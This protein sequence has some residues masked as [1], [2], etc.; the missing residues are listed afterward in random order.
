M[1]VKE[2][3]RVGI[4][5]GYPRADRDD[6]DRAKMTSADQLYVNVLRRSFP[7]FQLTSLFPADLDSPIPTGAGL[8]DFDAFIWTGSKLTIYKNEPN[9]TR[10]IEFSKALFEAGKPQFG[11]CWGVQMAAVAAGGEVA[12]MSQG[13]ET[14]VARKIKLT[15]E[16]RASKLYEGKTDAFDG[17]VNHLDEVT[18]IPPGGVLLSVGSHCH[19][20]ALE[21]RHKKGVFWG[22]QYHPEYNLMEMAR[23]MEARS[24]ALIKEGFFPGQKELKEHT[25]KMLRLFETPGDETLK[26]NLSIGPDILGSELREAE[27]RNF[28]KHLVF[29]TLKH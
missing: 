28:F 18:R 15:P 27:L 13:R 9:V 1:R 2:N 23:L 19:I 14:F 7:E 5:N 25:G 24:E 17:F 6:L 29:P 4:I 16:G 26:K 3:V 21:V 20:Q 22:L 11:S 8:A 12:K 10:Q